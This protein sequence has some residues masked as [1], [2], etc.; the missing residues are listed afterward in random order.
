MSDVTNLFRVLGDAARLRMLH[1]LVKEKLNVSELTGILGLAQSGVSR[2]LRLMKEAGLVT[3]R[4][5]GGWAYYAVDPAAFSGEAAA[6]RALL[7][8]GLDSLKDAHEDDV[9]LEEVL[10]QRHEEFREKT[11]RGIYP[12]RSWAAWARTLSYLAPPLTVA[13]LGCGE[14]YLALEVSR[15]ARK[16]IAID[17]SRDMLQRARRL[18]AKHGAKNIV[19]KKGDLEKLPLGAGSVEVALM[20]Q[21]LHSLSDPL[22]ALKEARRVLVPG[23]RLLIQELRAHQDAWVKERFGDKRLGF[24]ETELKRLLKQAG[25]TEIRLDIGAKRRGDPFTVLIGCGRT[26]AGAGSKPARKD[27]L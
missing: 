16:V 27:A 21:V 4:R 18:A 20:A 25:F 5:D 3:E 8:D 12:G 6:I 23:G 17:H 15:W 1:L 24:K 9:R 19:W 22:I 26:L 14:G 13:D 2:N 7:L 10:R 11:G